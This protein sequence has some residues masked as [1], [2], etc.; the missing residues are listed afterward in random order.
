[1][2]IER[3]YFHDS[4]RLEFEARVTA[5]LEHE[6]R[7]AVV[8]DRTAFH[9]TGGGQPHDTGDL[10]GAE[11][12]WR[13]DDVVEDEASGRILHVVS[14]DLSRVG[15]GARVPEVGAVVA[16][17]VDAA[18]R[19]DHLQQHTGQHILSQAFVRAA[20][21]ETRSFHLGA[22]TST[23]DV[24]PRVTD[25]VAARAV[26]LANEVV[27]SDRPLRV[28]V[29]GPEELDRFKI[30]RQAFHGA[31]IRLVEIDGF[32]VS[33]CSG[34]HAH[35]TGEVGLI[36]ILSVER[37]KGLHRV[38]FVCGGRALR[39]L[40]A[41]RAVVQGAARAL[42]T[43]ADAVVEQVESLVEQSAA[44]RKRLQRLFAL[45]AEQ[46]ALTLLARAASRG[47]AKLV[48]ELLR[49]HSFEEAQVLAR[50]ITE[51]AG[52]AV[53]ALLGVADPAAP[54][55]LFARSQD[56]SLASLSMGT[57]VKQVAERFGGRGG[58]SP[59]CGQ[60]SIARAADLPAALEAAASL[61]PS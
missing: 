48:A 42:S 29:V 34:T 10:A 39:E 5:T 2:Q 43:G 16:G 46:Q 50:T 41:A 56:P 14:R 59:S 47:A 1:V 33:A 24:D 57:L 18:R 21:L 53:V 40:E 25:E 27:F 35:R 9:P 60:A 45:V 61:L 20:G 58:G 52:A 55:L 15:E 54:K 8:L 23:I 12:E 7:P 17:R 37:A 22:R 19:R 3:L 51:R 30:R 44:Q 36:A 38:E 28:H 49:E 4:H 32:D 26:A 6:G 13:V 31:R 11:G